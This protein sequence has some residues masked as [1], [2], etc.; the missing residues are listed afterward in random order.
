MNTGQALM[1]LLETPKQADRRRKTDAERR[2]RNT[3][4]EKIREQHEEIERLYLTGK[5]I[6]DIGRLMG[7]NRDQVR[8]IL[9]KRGVWNCWGMLGEGAPEVKEINGVRYVRADVCG[10]HG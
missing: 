9:E 1:G 3:E 8:R 10:E 4:R 6:Y 5:R 2:R 7:M